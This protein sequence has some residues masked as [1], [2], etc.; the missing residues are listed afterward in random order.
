MTAFQLQTVVPSNGELFFVLPE[1]LRGKTV[2]VN[3]IPKKNYVENEQQSE[4][5]V[6][7]LRRLRGM[8]KGDID[9]SDLR[10]EEDREI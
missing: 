10:D 4:D 8:L 3:L 5:P 1:S 9:L 7:A 6:L 2:E